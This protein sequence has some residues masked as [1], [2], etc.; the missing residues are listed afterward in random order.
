MPARMSASELLRQ[1]SALKRSNK[2]SNGSVY[3]RQLAVCG[4][5]QL[6]KVRYTGAG[7]LKLRHREDLAADVEDGHEVGV[8]RDQLSLSTSSRQSPQYSNIA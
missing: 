8:V 2:W 1:Q 3:Y 6:C 7:R 4:L 5:L